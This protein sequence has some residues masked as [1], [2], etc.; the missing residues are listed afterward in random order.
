MAKSEVYS[1]RVA[2]AMKSALEGVARSEG[3]SVG[4]LLDEI[5]SGWIDD[6]RRNGVRTDRKLDFPETVRPRVKRG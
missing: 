4:A 1:W 2:P 6:Q 3:R 5:V